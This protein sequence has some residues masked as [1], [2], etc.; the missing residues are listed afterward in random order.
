[1]ERLVRSFIILPRFLKLTGDR[2]FRTQ[3][4]A[5]GP[6]QP[7]P[8][9]TSL[10]QDLCIGQQTGCRRGDGRYNTSRTGIQ[11]QKSDRSRTL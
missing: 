1:M 11:R 7:R 5:V 4:L 2:R 3:R 9:S 10:R 6:K 8:P